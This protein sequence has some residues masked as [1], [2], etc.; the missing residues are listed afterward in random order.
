MFGGG[1]GVFPLP[2]PVDRTLYAY[3]ALN[4]MKQVWVDNF[5]NAHS[6]LSSPNILPVN[7]SEWF[8]IGT[9]VTCQS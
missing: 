3:S 7:N 4:L 8:S 9:T 1:G 2:P 5:H 6:F